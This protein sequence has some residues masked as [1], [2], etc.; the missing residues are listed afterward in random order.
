MITSRPDRRIS[1]SRRLLREALLSLILEKGYDAVTIEDIT[2]RADLGRTT[3]YLHYKDKEALLLES[4]DAIADDLLVRVSQMPLPP[5][6][7]PQSIQPPGM[8][9]QAPVLLVFQHAA[10][11]ARLYRIILRGEGATPATGRL[12]QIVSTAAIAFMQERAARL[13]LQIHPQ[14]PVDVFA[15]YF[16]GSLLA[17]VTWWLE[18]EM[19]YPAEQMVEMFRAMF[20]DG[21]SQV[22]GLKSSA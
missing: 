17:L 2:S 16:A 15:S 21:A 7:D 19:P 20:F 22:L 10:Q 3:F 5:L 1:R 11:N 6:P 4:I 9:V 12:H 8:T 13:N 18:Q 14:V